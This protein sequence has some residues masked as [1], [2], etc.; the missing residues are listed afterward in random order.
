[1][2][3][4]THKVTTAK[5]TTSAVNATSVTETRPD[6]SDRPNSEDNLKYRG[7]MLNQRPMTIK[8]HTSVRVA[9]RLDR[10]VRFNDLC[11]AAAKAKTITIVGQFTEDASG[12][13]LSSMTP[14]VWVSRE[15]YETLRKSGSPPVPARQL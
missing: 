10:D 2:K 13:V 11:V 9:K 12:R 14:E 5:S 1:M 4:R 6:T 7:T 15:E 8:A 3:T